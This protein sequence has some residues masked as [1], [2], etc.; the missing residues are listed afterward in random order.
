MSITQRREQRCVHCSEQFTNGYNREF[1][2]EACKER[3]QGQKLLN[4]LYHDHTYC[5]LCGSRLKDIEPPKPEYAFDETGGAYAAESDGV[6]FTFFGQEESQKSAI[7]F[8]YTTENADNG[9]KTAYTKGDFENVTSGIVCG[10]CG[11][12]SL[13]SPQEDIRE[14]H[15][16]EYTRLIL[17]SLREQ[18]AQGVFECEIHEKTV[19]DVVLET[20]DLPLALGKARENN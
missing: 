10:E 14:R 8:E 15:L 13:A 7:G 3:E 9:L 4:T 20:A 1:C 18:K 5:A 19:F 6:S 2:S 16:L 11:N 12:A 17:D